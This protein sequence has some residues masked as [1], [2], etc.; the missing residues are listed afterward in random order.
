GLAKG[1]SS[2]V[3]A[4]YQ[5]S[6]LRVLVGAGGEQDAAVARVSRDGEATLP[7]SPAREL[8]ND[9][10]RGGVEN[11]HDRLA[12]IADRDPSGVR[13]ESYRPGDRS[14]RKMHRCKDYVVR[15]VQSDL[16]VARCDDQAAR[17]VEVHP[18]DATL[19]SADGRRGAV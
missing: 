19:V 5:S 4:P 15:S 12:P 10:Q 14:L 9:P 7:I 8:L 3:P 1:V 17:R 11:M 18:R 16:A 2:G 13:G 6:S